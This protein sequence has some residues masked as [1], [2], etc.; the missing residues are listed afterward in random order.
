V[1]LAQVHAVSAAV[2][3][4]IVGIGGVQRGRDAL[5]L[6]NAGAEVVAVGTESF[7]DPTA[8]R[9]VASELASLLDG[10]L[11]AASGTSDGYSALQSPAPSA[12]SG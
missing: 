10:A 8:G 7:R 6:L 3:V 9:R 2:A 12:F 5:D 11:A 4:P 1:A